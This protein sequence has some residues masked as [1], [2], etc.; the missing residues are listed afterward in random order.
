MSGGRSRRIESDS[1]FHDV[2]PRQLEVLRIVRDRGVITRAEI[3]ELLQSSASQVSRLSAPLIARH[4]VAVEPRLPLVEGRP[5]ELLA[6]ADDA[7]FVIGLDIGGLAQEAVVANLSGGVIGSARAAGPLPDSQ[8]SIIE[9]LVEL[10]DAAVVDAAISS[11]QILGVGAGVRAIIDPISGII[12]AGPEAPAWSPHWT[13]FDLR[14][15]LAN[16]LAGPKVVIDDTVRALAAAERRYGNAAGFDDFVYLLADSGIGATFVIDGH[17]Y[18]GPGHLAGEIGHIT[19]DRNGPLCGCGRRGCVECYASTSALVERARELDASIGAIGEVIVRSDAGDLGMQTVLTEGGAALGRAIAIVINL[20]SPALIVIGGA[21]VASHDYLEAA[22]ATA[23]AESLTQPFRTAC[24]VGSD[25]PINSGA[26]GAATL[27]L[28]EL[29]S[30]SSSKITT[31]TN[32]RR[33]SATPELDAT[34]EGIDR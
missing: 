1:P 4:L 16:A 8:H 22:R 34:Q 13:D 25:A 29:F 5:T 33:L 17:P 20:L 27:M 28:D 31:R 21:A 19:L 14:D 23:Q 11:T 32:A 9:R 26:H 2:T 24:I 30:P 18:I 3:A 7:H 10:V 12:S 15:Q 6:L